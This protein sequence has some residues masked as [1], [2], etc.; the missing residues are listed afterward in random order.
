MTLT[1]TCVAKVITAIAKF[2]EHILALMLLTLDIQHWSLRW[3]S[4]CHTHSWSLT[5]IKISFCLQRWI[6][7]LGFL[8]IDHHRFILHILCMYRVFNKEGQKVMG[9]ETMKKWAFEAT[10]RL[11]ASKNM[12]HFV[13][14]VICLI[15]SHKIYILKYM[16]KCTKFDIFI[17]NLSFYGYKLK[18]FTFHVNQKS[19]FC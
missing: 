1:I 11:I 12:G 6:S 9:Y 8:R 15:I 18:F 16:K 2:F 17:W 10:K 14:F 19:L 13:I 4:S 5:K 7:L 3:T